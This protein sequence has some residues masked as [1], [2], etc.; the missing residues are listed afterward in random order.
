MHREPQQR[1]SPVTESITSS[2]EPHNQFSAW[3]WRSR[4][5]GICSYRLLAPPKTAYCQYR[6]VHMGEQ[7]YIICTSL[8]IE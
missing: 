7:K 5:N 2:M 3:A 1:I 4:S 8:T 6:L